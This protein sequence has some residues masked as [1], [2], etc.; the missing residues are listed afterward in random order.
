VREAGAIP[1]LLALLRVGDDDSMC[2]VAFALA[3]ELDHA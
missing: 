3:D 1:V 2:N